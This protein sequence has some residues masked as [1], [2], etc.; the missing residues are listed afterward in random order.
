[1][2]SHITFLDAWIAIITA[3][4][5]LSFLVVLMEFM[6]DIL[7]YAKRYLKS[8]LTNPTPPEDP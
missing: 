4:F 5:F 3:L 2:N 7:G 8:K 6:V 1:M